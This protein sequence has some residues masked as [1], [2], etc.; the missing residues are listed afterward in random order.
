MLTVDSTAEALASQPTGSA[1]VDGEPTT[2]TRS[3]A[4]ELAH[5]EF[6]RFVPTQS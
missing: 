3:Q 2:E 5:Y 1:S 4:W 6:R